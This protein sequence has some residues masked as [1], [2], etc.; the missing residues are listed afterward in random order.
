MSTHVIND[1]KIEYAIIKSQNHSHT[2]V[3]I[4]IGLKRLISIE[5]SF[6]EIVEDQIIAP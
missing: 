4:K 5:I 3:T 1:R 6:K 2:S